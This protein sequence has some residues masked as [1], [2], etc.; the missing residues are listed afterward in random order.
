MLAFVGGEDRNRRAV[1]DRLEF[2]G[3][4]RVL[5]VSI[6]PGVNLPYLMDAPGAGEVFGLDLSPGQLRQ[7]QRLC[8]RRGWSVDLFLANAEQ[9]PFRNDSFDFVFH[10]G[11]IN[12]FNDKRAAIE[13]MIRV[14]RPGTKIM[15]IDEHERA[16]RLYDRTL[17]GFRRS[18]GKERATVTAPVDLVPA[19][20]EAV[21]LSSVWGGWFYCLEF[22]K[23]IDPFTDRKPA[24]LRRVPAIHEQVGPSDE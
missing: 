4:G 11:G 13:A 22:R 24:S 7:C 14:A 18:F 21:S 5:E 9:L 15:I 12:F 23:P 1:L 8:R 10:I 20:M 17:P 19:S 16:A 2:S 6:G 3:R